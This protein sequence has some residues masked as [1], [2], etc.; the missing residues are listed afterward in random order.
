MQNRIKEIRKAKNLTQT[1][2]G[3]KLGLKGNTIT[4]YETGIRTPSDAVINSICREFNVNEDWL[5]TGKGERFLQLSRDEEISA[6]IGDVLSGS[7][8]FKTRLV[9]VLSQ[10][11][12]E[13][14]ILLERMAQKL[15][16]EEQKRPT[17]IKG[18]LK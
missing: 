16:A 8:D 7:H 3:E 10:L 4:G 18:R 1:E 14:W 15:V 2:F 11:N 12:S 6:F 5:R 17:P 9:S 13:E